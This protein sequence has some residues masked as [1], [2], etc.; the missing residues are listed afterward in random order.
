MLRKAFLSLALIG[1][2]SLHASVLSDNIKK[3][4]SEKLGDSLPDNVS[5]SKIEIVSES[6]IDDSFSLPEWKMVHVRYMLSEDNGETRVGLEKVITNGEHIILDVIGLDGGVS[7]KNSSSF[8]FDSRDYLPELR[9]LGNGKSSDK[10]IVFSDP[11][12]PACKS[13]LPKLL[14]I[15]TTKKNLD[16]Y[17]IDNPLRQIHP[18]SPILSTLIVA[19]KADK[20]SLLKAVYE[21]G[22]RFNAFNERIKSIKDRAD[23]EQVLRD[24]I[25]SYN[26]LVKKKVDPDFKDITY[27]SLPE[28]S[29]KLKKSVALS[30]QYKINGTPSFYLNGT[31]VYPSELFSALKKIK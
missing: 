20:V 23:G 29:N 8:A 24:F 6:N 14:D 25:I 27:E 4:F 19:S 28:E 18:T 5:V 3:E 13:I 15:V 31:E 9:L 26:A 17:Y 12:C 30:L 2:L 10:L 11:E 21:A 7:L 16:F 1:G 22:D